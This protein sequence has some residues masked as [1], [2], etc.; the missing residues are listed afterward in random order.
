[1]WSS[2]RKLNLPGVSYNCGEIKLDYSLRKEEYFSSMGIYGMIDSEVQNH[3]ENLIDNDDAR[4]WTGITR[5]PDFWF[6][7]NALVRELKVRKNMS[8]QR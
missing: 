5:D 1:M 2:F 4:F 7:H 6:K 8:I 3:L